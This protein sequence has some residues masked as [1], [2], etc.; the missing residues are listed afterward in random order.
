MI[1][2]DRLFGELKM[3]KTILT[4][5]AA[6]L[7]DYLSR[8]HHRPEGLAT[9]GMIGNSTEERPYK[10]VVNLLGVERETAGGINAPMQRIADGG[11]VIMQTPLQM[12]LNVMQADSKSD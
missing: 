7:D 9:A 5:Y 1:F 8:T 11:Y 3:L 10:M 6:R 4:Y 12:N 2:R